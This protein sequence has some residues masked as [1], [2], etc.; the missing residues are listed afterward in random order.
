MQRLALAGAEQFVRALAVVK[1]ID[2]D[3]I[4][5]ARRHPVRHA[6]IRI[7]NGDLKIRRAAHAALAAAGIVRRAEHLLLLAVGHLKAVPVQAGLRRHVDL[8]LIEEFIVAQ[9]QR[10]HRI[11]MLFAIPNAQLDA[12]QLLCPRERHAQAD[13]RTGL[14]RAKRIAIK[15]LCRMMLQ[16]H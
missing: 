15:R 1:A 5:D 3:L 13:L 11:A 16:D 2:H 7:V 4:H 8:R 10:A 12:Q 6:V 14:E 9:P